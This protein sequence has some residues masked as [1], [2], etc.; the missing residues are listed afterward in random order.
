MYFKTNRMRSL[1]DYTAS[2]G[3]WNIRRW[4]LQLRRN[5]GLRGPR[6]YTLNTPGHCFTLFALTP[7]ANAQ[8]SICALSHSV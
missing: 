8:F 3:N 7:L 4:G 2:V 1:M 6:P 5:W